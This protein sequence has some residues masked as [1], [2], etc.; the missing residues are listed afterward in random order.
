MKRGILII[1][2]LSAFFTIGATDI[3][4]ASNLF[5]NHWSDEK[6]VIIIDHSEGTYRVSIEAYSHGYESIKWY[7]ICAYDETNNTLN[8]VQSGVK[9][10]SL[11]DDEL[12]CEYT[13]VDYTNG[14]AYF[15]IQDGYLVWKD[16]EEDAG[17]DLRFRNMGNFEGRWESDNMKID[18]YI[19]DDCYRCL[20]TRMEKEGRT[21]WEYLCEYDEE[22]KQL[23]SVYGLKETY[24]I[25]DNEDGEDAIEEYHDGV[26]VFLIN[27]DGDLLWNELK[28][29]AGDGYVFKLTQA[30]D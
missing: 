27:R 28:E 15:M 19:V 21:Q 7:Y 25:T 6:H 17:K 1:L 24:Y 23:K 13:N 5:L 30:Q 2:L 20:I 16:V 18:L 26:A 8:A 10:T 12:D 22:N 4:D 11:F 9:T 3:E 29:N 14:T